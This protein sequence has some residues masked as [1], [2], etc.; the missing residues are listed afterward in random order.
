[1]KLWAISFLNKTA[2]F[3]LIFFEIVYGKKL[4]DNNAKLSNFLLCQ[5]DAQHLFL[6]KSMILQE[7][8]IY[9]FITETIISF[10][11]IMYRD[12]RLDLNRI[13]WVVILLQN[14]VVSDGNWRKVDA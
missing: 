4:I 10:C 3:L 5:H 13:F 11:K 6:H 9:Y 2:S 14:L 12:E 1:V 8:T 7:L